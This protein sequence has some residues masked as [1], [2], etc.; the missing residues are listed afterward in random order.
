M[1]TVTINT[2]EGT[3]VKVEWNRPNPLAADK[4]VAHTNLVRGLAADTRA[5]VQAE[6]DGV[7]KEA[8]RDGHHPYETT[9]ALRK[10]FAGEVEVAEYRLRNIART[11]QLDAYRAGS[12]EAELANSD[13][14]KGWRWMASLS[15]TSCPSC[16]AMHGSLHPI[17]ES[18]PDDHP[19]G[20]CYRVPVTKD[21]G[22]LGFTG[23]DDN[24]LPSTTGEAWFNEQSAA[25]QRQLLGGR[26]YEAW[27]AG[28]YRTKDWVTERPAPDGWRRSFVPAKAPWGPWDIK[29]VSGEATAAVTEY[30]RTTPV[31]MRTSPEDMRSIAK[32][33]E[34]KP[35]RGR[36]AAADKRLRRVEGEIYG[37]PSA[38]AR[39][40]Y[41]FM[42]GAPEDY[43]EVV[44][45]FKGG[46][47]NRAMVATGDSL[48]G[49]APRVAQPLTRATPDAVT[50]LS[51][52]QEVAIFGRLY[53]D[54]VAYVVVPRD[55]PPALLESLRRAGITYRKN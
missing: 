31:M 32:D 18:G 45:V 42:G 30:L 4:A 3:P 33:G 16:I 2:P 10:A 35:R 15:P 28:A 37:I 21:W 20:R 6:L 51:S 40:V 50:S 27:R 48:R 43:G 14:L 47:K 13:V 12:R 29:S 17:D 55:V 52:Q 8:V 38:E 53:T 22:E 36:G 39:P 19:Q 25:V 24:P 23:V 34:F 41:G 54:D 9:R 5:R 11:E 26:G 49:R 1:S 7:L 46:V 44:V